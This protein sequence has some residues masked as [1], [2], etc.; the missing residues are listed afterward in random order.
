MPIH[1]RA[2]TPETTYILPAGR[3]GSQHPASS[4]KIR[5]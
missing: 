3:P 1:Y 5:L 4:G 2:F